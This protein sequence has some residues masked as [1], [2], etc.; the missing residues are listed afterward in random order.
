MAPDVTESDVTETVTEFEATEADAIEGEAEAAGSAP[1]A[2]TYAPEEEAM[3]SKRPRR[4]LLMVHESFMPPDDVAAMEEDDYFAMKTECDVVHGLRQLGHDVQ[5]VGLR[6]E[7]A[8]L[9]RVLDE[10]RPHVVFNLLEEF[11]DQI[12][13]DAHVVG[14]LELKGVKY[15]GCNPRGLVLARDKA[16]SKKIL[17]YHRIRAP[18]F[19]VFPRGRRVKRQERLTFPVIVKSLVAEGSEGIAQ[20]SIVTS[21][22]ALAER[23]AFI[24]E[25]VQTDAIAEQYIE[26]REV[27]ASVFGLRRLEVMPIWEIILDGLPDS[28]PRIATSQVKWNLEYQKKHGIDTVRARDLSPEIE[29]HIAKTAKR[30]C[31]RLNIDGYARVDFRL[32]AEGELYF[33]EANPNPDIAY[34]EEL[35]ASAEAQGHTYEALLERVIRTGLR[36]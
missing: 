26:G 23:V 32:T 18:R 8:S 11:K 3:R 19:Q 2:E 6:D 28:A 16:L 5:I 10:W 27:Y 12:V 29:A 33:L 9:R 17:S 36:R 22:A 21:D 35:A 31:R 14:Y 24:H 13:Y 25:H 1:G 30:I 34:G 15:T 20:R 7:I 4:V